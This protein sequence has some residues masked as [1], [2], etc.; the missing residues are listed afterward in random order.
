MCTPKIA[1]II[2]N[3]LFSNKNLTIINECTISDYSNTTSQTFHIKCGLNTLEYLK[4]EF[5]PELGCNYLFGNKLPYDSGSI[6]YSA[7]CKLLDTELPQYDIILLKGNQSDLLNRIVPSISGRVHDI[8]CFGCPS[9]DILIYDDERL[10]QN[11]CILHDENFKY[12]TAYKAKAIENWFQTKYSATLIFDKIKFLY[13]S[14][15]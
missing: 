12:C 11:S 13:N 5:K 2:F 7:F 9:V 10:K 14:Y 3:F 4:K 15:D 6:K 8:D 1:I